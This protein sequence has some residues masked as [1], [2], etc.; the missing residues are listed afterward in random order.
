MTYNPD[1]DIKHLIQDM[2]R[3]G[4]KQDDGTYK[5]TFIQ[6]FKDP[7]VEQHFESL[8]GTMKAARKKGIINFK[9]ELLL[10]GR[11]NNVEITLLKEEL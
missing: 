6:L 7:I 9:G 11:D 5:T 8:F 10:Q 2:K 3:I 4:T 1:D